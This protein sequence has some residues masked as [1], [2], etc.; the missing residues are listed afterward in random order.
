MVGVGRDLCGSSS[1][2][3]LAKQGHL[4]QAAQDLVQARIV[5]RKLINRV[6]VCTARLPN[7]ASPSLVKPKKKYLFKMMMK[8]HF[9]SNIHL[10]S[11][12]LSLNL[13]EQY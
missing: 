1:P 2:T 8:C 3:L 9:K 7:H 5:D 6:A 11:L 12:K 4:Q 13:G 10:K